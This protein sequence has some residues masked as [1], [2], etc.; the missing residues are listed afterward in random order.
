MHEQLG[1][2]KTCLIRLLDWPDFAYLVACPSF[3]PTECRASSL[4]RVRST[5]TTFSLSP[6]SDSVPGSE[7]ELHEDVPLSESESESDSAVPVADLGRCN[8]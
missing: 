1:D 5:S 6:S 4:P 7:L 8:I 2:L 3:D